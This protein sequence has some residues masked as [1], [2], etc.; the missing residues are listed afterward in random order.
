[1]RWLTPSNMLLALT[2]GSVACLLLCI[3]VLMAGQVETLPVMH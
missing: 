1:M 2:I 3:L